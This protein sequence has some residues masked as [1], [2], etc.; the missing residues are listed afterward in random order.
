MPV[1]DLCR[2]ALFLGAATSYEIR[3]NALKV[4]DSDSDLSPHAAVDLAAS[5]A[6]RRPTNSDATP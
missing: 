4:L 6:L 2:A 3:R 1:E 5:R